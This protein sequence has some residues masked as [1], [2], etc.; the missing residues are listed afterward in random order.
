MKVVIAPDSFKGSMSSVQAAEAIRRGLLQ[1]DSNVIC[2]LIPMADGGEGT[3]DAL[4][5]ITGGERIY[6]QVED[7]LGRSVNAFYGWVEE[8]KTA[9][10]EMAAASGLPLLSQSEL[11]P[12]LASTY[13]TGQLIVDAV[14]R[15]AQTVILGLG[16]SATVDGGVGCLQALGVEFQDETG[17]VIERVGGDLSR[18][19]QI[20]ASAL[21]RRCQEIE[22]ILATDVANPLL[23]EAG[24]VRV[25]GGQKGV[26]KDEFEGFE[27]G[28]GHYAAL[29]A[30]VSGKSCAEDAGSG[31]AGGLGFGIR[32]FLN[33][34]NE[35]GFE[36][37]AALGDLREKIRGADLVITGEGSIDEQSLY[38]KVPVGI[39]GIAKELRVPTVVFAGKIAGD[40]ATFVRAG[41]STVL[42]IVDRPL[43]LE[44]AISSGPDLLERASARFAQIW[45][46]AQ[47]QVRTESIL[48]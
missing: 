35:S 38:G 4:Q 27:R 9:I 14:S 34:R 33:A 8:T 16:G 10:I 26:A 47:S 24:A 15:G 12:R 46:L 19:A 37:I 31:A 23:G 32:S 30:R 42:P 36:L 17:S 2:E 44:E 41:I 20:D 40:Q 6:C 29:V 3:V 18:I 48:V 5:V 39:A 7:P 28:M 1:V 22:F 13:G 11:N 43:K 25:F 21:D 45:F